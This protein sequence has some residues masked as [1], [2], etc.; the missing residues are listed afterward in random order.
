M[1]TET[2]PIVVAAEP[3]GGMTV[4]DLKK[5]LEGRNDNE[6]LVVATGYR[7]KQFVPVYG[8]SDDRGWLVMEL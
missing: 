7:H 5:S 4:G 6:A 2:I 3:H 8:I 1:I